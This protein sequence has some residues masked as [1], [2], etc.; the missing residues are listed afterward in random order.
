MAVNSEQSA[1]YVAPGVFLPL[2]ERN[3][4]RGLPNPLT[5]E[6]LQRLGV[7]D[8]LVPRTLQAFKIL[9]LIG[10]DGRH[11]DLLEQF[12]RAPEA[13]YRPMMAEWLKAAYAHALDV[14]DPATAD[15]VAIR[16]A[17]RHYNPISMQP[18]MI[19]LFTALFEAAGVR[20]SM[21]K[22]IAPRNP[23]P[24]RSASPRLVITRA[25][26][27]RITGRA[28]G[29]RPA[30]PALAPSA[31]GLHPALAGL[32]ASL[33]SSGQGWTQDARD[34]WYTAFGVVLDFAVPVRAAEPPEPEE[35]V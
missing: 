19:T 17:F 24:V 9:D 4:D 15:D 12:R 21:P 23:G 34:R 5:A 18:R 33:P 31:P 32:L 20:Q 35:A 26:A 6:S 16:D 28:T 2:L 13:D 3:R 30:P 10:E 27:E 22:A 11:T 1:P 8:S 29:E 14:I 25:M 7:S